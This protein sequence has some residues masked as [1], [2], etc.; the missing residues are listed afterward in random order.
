MSRLPGLSRAT[1][2]V[3]TLTLIQLPSLAQDIPL[4]SSGTQKQ[5]D[6]KDLWN[7]LTHKKDTLKRKE[8]AKFQWVYFPAGGYS[9]NTGIAILGGAN[10]LW[11]RDGATKQSNASTSFTYTQF[12]QTILP[13]VVNVWTKKDR[14]NFFLDNRYIN[15]PSNLY[16]LRGR[17]KLDSGYSVNFSWLKM[18]PSVL[19]RISNNLYGGI[20]LYYDYF[21]DIVES[22]FQRVAPTTNNPLGL[23]SAF[24]YYVGQ[25]TPPGKETA[26]GPAVKLL[27]DSRDNPVNASKGFFGSAVFHP[28]FKSWGSDSSWST[29]ALDARK[30]FS[31]S[32]RRYSVLALWAY[33]WQDFGRAPFLLLPSTGWDDYWNTGRGY[34]QGRYRGHI[35][36]YLEAEYRFQ[37][38]KNGLLGGVLFSNIQ[39]FPNELF[40]SYSEYRGRRVT[41]VTAVGYGTGVRFKFN[42]YSK[43]NLCFDMGF[44]QQFPKPWFAVNLSEVF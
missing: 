19:M 28:S 41:N 8:E 44:G 39:N 29:L 10:A 35:M 26:F 18:H 15:Y 36:R 1:L 31:L 40:T 42:K 25:P 7:R 16:G 27:F 9:S 5:T 12:R 30:Y 23:S 4:D 22:G 14:F 43:T 3:L 6:I 34:S 21:W 33:Y 20:G 2:I 37:I 11:T 13:L 38:L 17:S 24:E 32:D